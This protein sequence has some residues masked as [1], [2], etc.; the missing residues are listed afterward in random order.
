MNSTVSITGRQMFASTLGRARLFTP[1]NSSCAKIQ[2]SVARRLRQQRNG[3]GCVAHKT[4]L[5]S[6]AT[7]VYDA[8]VFFVA[9]P[10]RNATATRR[11]PSGETVSTRTA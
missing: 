5:F 7:K 6:V 2:E 11:N 8:S 10:E 1:M 3:F 9:T 4:H